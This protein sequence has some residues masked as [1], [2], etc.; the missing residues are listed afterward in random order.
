MLDFVQFQDDTN[1]DG[2]MMI[3]DSS[4]TSSLQDRCQENRQ[5]LSQPTFAFDELSDE[6]KQRV[7][8]NLI[9]SR[10]E[11]CEYFFG[12]LSRIEVKVRRVDLNLLWPSISHGWNHDVIACVTG[13]DARVNVKRIFITS[14]IESSF[15]VFL[16]SM[17]FSFCFVDVK[18]IWEISK[19]MELNERKN[20]EQH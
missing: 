19:S 6:Q 4:C 12:I 18:S 10:E 11:S 17:I 13:N 2:T 3:K 7:K 9:F 15:H 14:R 1:L 8:V 20:I 5:L 16:S